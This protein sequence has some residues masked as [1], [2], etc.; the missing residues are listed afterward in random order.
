MRKYMSRAAAALVFPL[1][2]PTAAGAL[3]FIAFERI[4]IAFADGATEA[5][6]WC[7]RLLFVSRAHRGLRR[8]SD[9]R[10]ESRHA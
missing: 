5:L 3:A 1:C 9:S 8:R 4:V 7:E 10:K 2:L 6:G